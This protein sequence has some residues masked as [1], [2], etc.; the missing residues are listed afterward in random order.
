[1]ASSS[2][3][4]IQ[5]ALGALALLAGIAACVLVLFEFGEATGR[6]PLHVRLSAV[7]RE[8]VGL[9]WRALAART[10][11]VFADRLGGA[12][13]RYFQDADKETVLTVMFIGL[14][15]VLIPAA[16]VLNLL[17]GGSAFLAKYYLSLLA[18]LVLL[19]FTGEVRALAPVNGAAALYLGA[20]LFILIPLYVFRSF[21]T[22]VRADEFS[23]AL[24]ESLLVAP[25]C[26]LVAFGAKLALDGM[27]W[28]RLSMR[29][30]HPFIEAVQAFLASLPVAFVMVFVALSVGTSIEPGVRPGVSWQ[31]LVSAIAF[32]SAGV[33]ATLVILRRALMSTGA[34][35]LPAG[36]I[37]AVGV[38]AALAWILLF[39]GHRGALRETTAEGAFNVLLGLSPSG[40]ELHLG[41]DFWVM[42][43]PMFPVAS[44]VALVA[45]AWLAKAV[46]APAVV[47]FGPGYPAR[48][49]LL[50]AGAVAAALLALAWI[51]AAVV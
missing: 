47:V 44:L 45:V 8:A 23:H 51:V 35:A 40:S 38:S 15:F 14:V 7:W 32:S 5:S 29:L 48:R 37:A 11:S 16:A 17:I 21:A 28:R 10:V 22:L 25:L 26:Y 24:L 39:V 20:S 46:A 1:M 41:A 19:N 34:L 33:A 30:S 36:C 18:V 13:R 49:P 27:V 6:R 9:G 4:F 50:L 42:H 43:L 2:F 31:Y 12:V 3:Q